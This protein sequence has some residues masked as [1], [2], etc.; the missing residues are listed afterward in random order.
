[1]SAPQSHARPAA[2]LVTRCPEKSLTSTLL[3]AWM[4][5]LPPLPRSM[6]YI[7]SGARQV[8]SWKG[9][10]PLCPRRFLIGTDHGLLL[11]A[12]NT[13]VLL[14]V[15]AMVHHAGSRCL[16]LAGVCTQG[17]SATMLQM[18]GEAPHPAPGS[19]LRPP[20]ADISSRLPPCCRSRRSA[21][22]GTWQLSAA[23]CCGWWR[24]PA[25]GQRSTWGSWRRASCP[26]RASR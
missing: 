16:W 18:K 20:A 13:C 24:R 3:A 7:L 15:N 10:M 23:P 9:C 8:P 26:L 5:H 14:Q 21:L 2:C 6:H 4:T 11:S 1:M 22:S 25:G 19:H 12:H 17:L